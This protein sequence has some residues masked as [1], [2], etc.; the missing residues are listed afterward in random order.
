MNM[1]PTTVAIVPPEASE[2]DPY[3][4]RYIS[5][6]DGADIVRE[7]QQQLSETAALLSRL[8]EQQGSYRYAPDKWSVK[9][10]LGHLIDTERIFAYRA[11]RIA[12]NDSTPIEGFEQDDYV[13]YGRFNE[14]P[15]ATL[16][17]EFA[18]VR[19]ASLF[20]FKHLDTVAWMRR[21]IA[22]RQE[23]SVRALAYVIAGHELHHRRILKD[24][25]LAAT[26]V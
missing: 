14:R 23:I 16:A 15:L 6:V 9:E 25:Y 19:Q 21:G 26:A 11:L 17:E 24:R 13:P 3:Y 7:M 20:L 2:Y 5:L 22:N 10:M 1:S 4:G 8:T 12:R 18:A